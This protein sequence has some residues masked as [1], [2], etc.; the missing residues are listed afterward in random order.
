MNESNSNYNDTLIVHH[1]RATG[2]TAA[3]PEEIQLLMDASMCVLLDVI[4]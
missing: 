2:A 4:K 3:A 1:V